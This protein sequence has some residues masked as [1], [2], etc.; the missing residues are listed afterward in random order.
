MKNTMAFLAAGL[1][2]VFAGCGRSGD[3]KLSDSA[4]ALMEAPVSS[5]AI[6]GSA[7]TA[8]GNPLRAYE[9]KLVN[10][11]AIEPGQKA[12]PDSVL[13]IIVGD[14]QVPVE[15]PNA[16]HVIV[17]GKK[18]DINLN[19]TAGSVFLIPVTNPVLGTRQC[20]C[21]IDEAVTMLKSGKFDLP[22]ADQV[23]TF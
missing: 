12:P 4:K 23:L 20:E 17:G 11:P 15:F 3:G 1:A 19:T 16:R 7:K 8:K 2:L 5:Q 21:Q 14:P 9:V 6:E 13:V 18:V 10:K 22:L